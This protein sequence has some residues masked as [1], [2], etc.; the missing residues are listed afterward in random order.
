MKGDV[1][2]M[3]KVFLKKVSAAMCLA[4]LFTLFNGLF[5]TSMVLAAETNLALGK[6]ITASSEA[7]GYEVT[8][9]ND[10]SDASRWVASSGDYP[11]WIKVDLGQSYNISSTI[12]K[13]LESPDGRYWFYKIEVSNDDI[14]YTQV[15]D[16]TANTAPGRIIDEFSTVLARYVRI[17]MTGSSVPCWAS[18]FELEIYS[19][20]PFPVQKNLALGKIAAASSE[21]AGYEAAKVNDGSA[22][23]RW[24]AS[25]GTYPQWVKID[26][27][28]TYS[29]SKTITEFLVNPP[30]GRNWKYKIE[31]SQDD[32]TYILLVDRTDNSLQG[33]LTDLFAP[34]SARYV[35]ITVTGPSV[36]CWASIREFEV[37]GDLE[38]ESAVLYNTQ[39][40]N[41]AAGYSGT[42]YAVLNTDAGSYI[43]WSVESEENIRVKVIKIY[44][45]NAS[46]NAPLKVEINGDEINNSL[47]FN[48]TQAWN[49]WRVQKI[50]IPLMQG[51]N[52]IRLTK[53]YPGA[54]PYIDKLEIQPYVNDNT[55]VLSDECPIEASSYAPGYPPSFA[56]DYSTGSRWVAANGTYP[57]W[58]K[59]DLGEV[60]NISYINTIFTTV[61]DGRYYKYTIEVSED[62]NAYT[63]VVDRSDNTQQGNITD[64]MDGAVNA[65]YVRLNIAGVFLPGD[66]P[67]VSAAS[68]AMV[69][70]CSRDGGYEKEYQAENAMAT[71]Y[72]CTV[73]TTDNGYTG[74]GYVH[75]N[76]ISGS[77]TE[78]RVNVEEADDKSLIFRYANGGSTASLLLQ[79]NGVIIDDSLDFTGTGGWNTWTL[80]KVRAYLKEGVNTI[81]LKDTSSMQLNIDKLDVISRNG[82]LALDASVTASSE[83][84]SHYAASN[85]IDDIDGQAGVGE[86]ASNGQQNPWIQLTWPN[87]VK[88]DKVVLYDREGLSDDVNS[89]ILSFSDGSSIDV[90]G[91]ATDGTRKVIKFSEK[92]VGWVKFTVTGGSGPNVGLAEIQVYANGGG[93]GELVRP[94]KEIDVSAA[95]GG[96]F[97][98]TGDVDGDNEI[99]IISARNSGIE[100]DHYITA[101][102][103]H[104]LDGTILWTWGTANSGSYATGFDLPVQIYDWDGDGSNEILFCTDTQL[105]VLNG[106]DGTEKR[107]L[108][109]PGGYDATDS[110][111]ICNVSGN[112]RPTDIIVKTR[113]TDM[114]AY[115]Y[116]WNQLWHVSSSSL[117]G[118]I[119]HY[120]YAADIDSDGKDEISQAFGMID[121]D[122]TFLWRYDGPWNDF[123]DAHEDSSRIVVNGGDVPA[124]YRIAKTYCGGNG[125]GIFDGT[126]NLIWE[127]RGSHFESLDVADINPDIPGNEIVVDIDHFRDGILVYDHDGNLIEYNNFY[128]NRHNDLV[129]WTG[130]GYADIVNCDVHSVFD[131]RFDIL[132]ELALPEGIRGSRIGNG[133]MN[134]D[135]KKDV[136]ILAYIP[137]TYS[138]KVYIYLNSNGTSGA[139]PLGCGV[140]YTN[141]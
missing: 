23:G 21:A 44:Y 47:N 79:V 97:F 14:N 40:Q 111:Y 24:V 70:V 53:D 8:K 81:R 103:A 4:I 109:L 73:E 99:E 93:P 51:R 98:L 86:W 138:Y 113:Y 64:Y 56:V 2:I 30:D 32:S 50:V 102:V 22:A 125:I 130:D 34:V 17:T 5:N 88:M 95:Y 20:N 52:T 45:S 3:K 12:L 48:S 35:R 89:G 11:Q 119:A 116:N 60:Y 137:D 100:S 121:D 110:I 39:V 54:G 129:E 58:L 41:T 61:A 133:D 16:K 69:S 141:Y 136:A 42:G 38:A 75:F 134:G 126:G 115:D 85:V 66:Q 122:G 1:Y 28:G 46:S 74:A 94:W 92:T 27:G 59:L 104:N 29:F 13:F 87:S 84:G 90:S 7:T 65:R 37:Y 62:N 108:A 123:A 80:R 49:K 140:N 77:Y 19:T 124:D 105:K 78:W 106:A 26:L 118:K 9:V 83:Y 36:P 71:R 114:W 33:K 18:I 67:L 15:V 131:Y 132:A 101:L 25:D 128:Y 127:V 76:N 120:Q 6:T 10:G 139:M 112:A 96:Q 31:I 55:I 82:N 135:G 107:S 117:P 91:I 68:V 63:Q 43:E 57:Q 72:Y